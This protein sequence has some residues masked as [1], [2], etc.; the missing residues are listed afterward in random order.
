MGTSGRVGVHDAP[1]LTLTIYV[2]VRDHTE[3]KGLLDEAISKAG[4]AT[5]GI[6]ARDCPRR[7]GCAA[8]LS[9][10]GAIGDGDSLTLLNGEHGAID[11][12][13]A[14]A[15]TL[16]TGTNE[17]ENAGLIETRGAGG[18]VIESDLQQDGDLV[19]AGAG[20]LTIRNAEVSGDGAT[21]IERGASLVLDGGELTF[22]GTI[23]IDAGGVLRPAAY[24]GG[25]L[26]AGDIE[27]N[28]TI[29]IAAGTVFILAGSVSG[30]G[31]IRVTSNNFEEGSLEISGGGASLSGG[32]LILSDSIYNAVVCDGIGGEQFSNAGAISGAGYIGDGA[33]RLFNTAA[34]VIDADD[35][36]G[37]SIFA[38]STA[39]SAGAEAVNENAGTMETTG[40]GG[41][42]IFGALENSGVV[43]ADGAGALTLDGALIEGGDGIVQTVGGGSIVLKGDAVIGNQTELWISAGGALT[44]TAGD[45]GDAI[46]TNVI[47]HGTIS[48]ADDSSLF[49]GGRWRNSGVMQL[50]GD[51]AAFVIEPGSAW[52]LL[53]GGTITL[54]G[55]ASEIVSGGAG[56]A[57]DNWRNVIAGAGQLGDLGMTID[58]SANGM[59]EATGGT[60]RLDAAG[61]DNAGAMI[62][63]AGGKMLIGAAITNDGGLI[64]EFPAESSDA[65]GD[66]FGAGLAVIDG[67]GSIEFGGAVENDVSFGGRPMGA[68]IVDHS[69]PSGEGAAFL[70]EISGFA[71][72]DTIDLRDLAFHSGQMSDSP[73]TFG[74]L[75]ASL[76][77]NNGAIDSAAFH[78][79]GAYTSGEFQFASDGHGG[80]AVTLAKA[81]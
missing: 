46:V 12:N 50:D 53:G 30:A 22:G 45:A 64:A 28:G 77:V 39:V 14:A 70:G 62:T 76:I 23:T 4:Q 43:S 34:G 33:L 11:A 29:R 68:L 1:T 59:I 26:D 65:A 36:K 35:S 81:V 2:P 60:L 47:N 72:G 9:G 19:A 75:D 15:L 57:L 21:T 5:H 13:R 69:T 8:R 63:T 80:T 20:A 31:A 42:T 24:G 40:A 54:N 44:T 74:S 79:L 48:V 52:E 10:S 61:L 6:A 27:N 66:V 17:I 55:S 49:V 56:A 38:D 51:G 58:N 7:V 18:L 32:S 67:A 37:L 16:D 41:L 71:A 78:L 73:S 25:E 3:T